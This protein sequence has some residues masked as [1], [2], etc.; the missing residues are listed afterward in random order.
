MNFL[1]YVWRPEINLFKSHHVT[2]SVVV[3][4]QPGQTCHIGQNRHRRGCLGTPGEGGDGKM[5]VLKVW[6]L[7]QQDFWESV[8]NAHSWALHFC[9]RNAGVGAQV[10]LMHIQG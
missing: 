6:S 2:D 8:R 1:A 7:E 10:I 5:V 9:I 4:L 3:K